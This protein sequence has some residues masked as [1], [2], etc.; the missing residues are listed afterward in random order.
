LTVPCRTSWLGYFTPPRV[1]RIW[2]LFAPPSERT[3][4]DVEAVG[5][6]GTLAIEAGRVL[7]GV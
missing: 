2:S 3:G 1:G 6:F 7:L 5:L 4:V